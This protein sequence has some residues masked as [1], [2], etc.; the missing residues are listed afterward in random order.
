MLMYGFEENFYREAKNAELSNAVWSVKIRHLKAAFIG[1]KLTILRLVSAVVCV[2]TLLA[3]AVSFGVKLPYFSADSTVS[4][5]GLYDSFNNGLLFYILKMAGSEAF[6]PEFAALRNLIIAFASSALIVVAVLLTSILCFVSWQKMQKVTMTIA[7]IGIADCAVI[8]V[9]T[10]LFLKQA[11]GAHFVSG[12]FIAGPLALLAGFVFV[13]VINYLLVKKG[14]PIE[15]VEGSVERAEIHKKVKSGEVKLDD[16]PYP[17][18][19][20]E[21]TRKIDEEI[22]KAQEGLLE[23]EMKAEREASREKTEKDGEE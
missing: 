11:A 18:V 2:A 1:S 17:I 12:G 21:A 16:L 19:E 8:G 23:A 15:Y 5:L 13:F 3:P 20:T 9:F 7:L 14:I 4:G 10:G 22:R 6:G